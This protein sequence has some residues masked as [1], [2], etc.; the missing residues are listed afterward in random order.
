MWQ[1]HLE[2]DANLNVDWPKDR[3]ISKYSCEIEIAK[4][5]HFLSLL[6]YEVGKTNYMCIKFCEIV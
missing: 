1:I 5:Y 4:A 2:W 6:Y 3:T